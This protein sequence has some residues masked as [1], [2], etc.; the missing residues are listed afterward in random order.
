[1][2][3]YNYDPK[4]YHHQPD[5]DDPVQDPQ[6]FRD[7]LLKTPE[8]I[9]FYRGQLSSP[10]THYHP[11]TA[12]R[13][14]STLH[15]RHSPLNLDALEGSDEEAAYLGELL[16]FAVERFLIPHPDRLEKPSDPRTPR[17]TLRCFWWARR[18]QQRCL[19]LTSS[20]RSL[21]DAAVACR[22][23]AAHAEEILETMENF[24]EWFR[25]WKEF[26][27]RGSVMMSRKEKPENHDDAWLSLEEACL[28][29]ER[30]E[31][32]ILRW[33]RDGILVCTDDEVMRDRL[34][35]ESSLREALADRRER[36]QGS[37][38]LARD[39]RW[40]DAS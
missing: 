1:M 22:V 2:T 16:R 9:G 37:M 14:P 30:S 36:L 25:H 18:D 23:L 4:S 17:L 15:G 38:E 40:R 32:T 35:R 31:R 21:A 28:F 34:I 6:E 39:H 11:D 13:R 33:M 27:S 7:F 20:P 12:D 29:A 3:V 10:V 19:G 8:M 24:N 26:R 5:H